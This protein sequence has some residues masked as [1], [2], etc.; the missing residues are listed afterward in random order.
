MSQDATTNTR[1]EVAMLLRAALEMA[2]G[3]SRTTPELFA[4]VEKARIL[5]HDEIQP[6][7]RESHECAYRL[8]AE[9]LRAQVVSL[10]GEVE[11]LKGDVAMLTHKRKCDRARLTGI[12]GMDGN[13]ALRPHLV[14]LRD[15]MPKAEE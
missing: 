15:S 14:L 3:S 1:D 7:R 5:L 13:E 12:L 8:D 4:V 11:S 9:R 10:E 2:Y 6:T